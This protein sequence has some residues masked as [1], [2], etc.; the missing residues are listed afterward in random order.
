[1]SRCTPLANLKLSKKTA[2][3]VHYP[4][5]PLSSMWGQQLIVTVVKKGYRLELRVRSHTL[6]F[7]CRCM[8]LLQLSL[9]CETLIILS[10]HKLPRW[11]AQRLRTPSNQDQ[12]CSTNHLYRPFTIT[13]RYKVPCS[14]STALH[15]HQ[16]LVAF[17]KSCTISL[18]CVTLN[19]QGGGTNWLGTEEGA[20]GRASTRAPVCQSE[21][22]M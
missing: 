8:T 14:N 17:T 13:S 12:I 9:V 4:L 20:C 1:M 11:G 16:L 5:S 6:P 15:V 2:H 22:A 18:P 10:P 19:V 7:L 21:A 3:S